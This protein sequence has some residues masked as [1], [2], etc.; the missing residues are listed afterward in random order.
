MQKRDFKTSA[1]GDSQHSRGDMS[2]SS[3]N[4]PKGQTNSTMELSS[5][6][7]TARSH[8]QIDKSASSSSSSEQPQAENNNVEVNNGADLAAVEKSEV[9]PMPEVTVEAAEN[10]NNSNNEASESHNEEHE[11]VSKSSSESSSSEE[12]DSSS[13]DSDKSSS[14]DSFDKTDSS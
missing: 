1:S 14:N 13:S 12:S 11:R 3:L 4:T 9:V 2:P 10:S 7:A 8:A 5:R 6:V